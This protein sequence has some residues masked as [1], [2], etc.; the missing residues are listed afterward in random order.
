MAKLALLLLNPGQAPALSECDGYV[1][2]AAPSLDSLRA[3]AF[4][5]SF[6]QLW[7][8]H[9]LVAIEGSGAFSEVNFVRICYKYYV[10]GATCK[11]MG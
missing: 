6:E 8:H 3:L 5:S 10:V 11:R 2:P 7:T 1:I 4:I 9:K